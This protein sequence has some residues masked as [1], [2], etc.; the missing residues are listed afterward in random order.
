[1]HLWKKENP[2]SVNSVS[3][4]NYVSKKWAYEIVISRLSYPDRFYQAS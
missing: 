4:V 1:M 3:K 2:I